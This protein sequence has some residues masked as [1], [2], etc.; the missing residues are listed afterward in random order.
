MM[1]VTSC[2]WIPLG[3]CG[4]QL[5][6]GDEDCDDGNDVDEDACTN[7]CDDAI[8]G[9]GIVWVGQE[10]CDLGVFNSD[11]GNCGLDCQPN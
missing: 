10:G 11:T 6:E 2:T 5:V 3:V 8:C 7:E 9:D 4:N 1:A